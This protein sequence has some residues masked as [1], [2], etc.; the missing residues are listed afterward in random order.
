MNEILNMIMMLPQN[1]DILKLYMLSLKKQGRIKLKWVDSRI[2]M[3]YLH[4]CKK[5]LKKLRD[6]GSLPYSRING[7]FYYKLSDI[8]KLLQKNYLASKSKRNGIK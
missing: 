8:E 1:I 6:R 4:I 3:Q 2:A 7:K 5:T